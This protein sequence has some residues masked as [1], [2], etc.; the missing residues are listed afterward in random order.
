MAQL[1]RQVPVRIGLS[2]TPFPE[3]P[4]DAYGVC[5]FLD[6]TLFPSSYGAFERH[7]AIK[8]A[9]AITRCWAIFGRQSYRRRSLP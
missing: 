1:A 9:T 2:G 6:P 8:G 3:S 7:Y 5:R 4:L